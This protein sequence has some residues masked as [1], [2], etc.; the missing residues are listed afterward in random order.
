MYRLMMERREKG[1]EGDDA[2]NYKSGGGGGSIYHVQQEEEEGK[3]D[4]SKVT[5]SSFT[6]LFPV[7]SSHHVGISCSRDPVAMGKLIDVCRLA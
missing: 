6:F 1:K 5:L 7:Q 2:P 3:M 4:Q